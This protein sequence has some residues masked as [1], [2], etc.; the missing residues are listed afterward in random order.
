MCN[1]SGTAQP[2]RPSSPAQDQCTFSWV[3]QVRGTYPGKVGAMVLI[4]ADGVQILERFCVLGAGLRR[5]NEHAVALPL[6][7]YIVDGDKSPTVAVLHHVL[8]VV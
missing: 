2:A 5:G 1:C 4:F 7:L 3:E 8:Q 6:Y